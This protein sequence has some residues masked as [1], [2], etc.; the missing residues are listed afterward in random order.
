VE[1]LLLLFDD[2]YLDDDDECTFWRWHDGLDENIL[3][4][5]H[6]AVLVVL[7]VVEQW[8]WK[9]HVPPPLAAVAASQ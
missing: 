1:L 6:R 8:C 3:L 4:F 5:V 9:K 2:D 7:V